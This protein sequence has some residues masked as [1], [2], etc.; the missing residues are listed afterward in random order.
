MSIP[1]L[2]EGSNISPGAA[3]LSQVPAVFQAAV[4][5]QCWSALSAAPYALGRT[6]LLPQSKLQLSS[7]I[8][9]ESC[10]GQRIQK[11]PAQPESHMES[12]QSKTN[13]VLGKENCIDPRAECRGSAEILKPGLSKASTA[14]LM[15]AP[16]STAHCS[17]FT[18]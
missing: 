11:G 3:P 1:A 14:F 17:H 10:K 7:A 6:A 15:V 4:E 9:I 16:H 13:V 5:A 18:C 12:I 2:A 8:K